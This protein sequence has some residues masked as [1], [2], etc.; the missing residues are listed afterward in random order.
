MFRLRLAAVLIG[1]G[2]VAGALFFLRATPAIAQQPEL[3]LPPMVVSATEIPTPPNEIG[4]DVT[5]IT[6]A[7]IA[8]HQWRTLP[9]VLRAVPGLVVEQAG[10]PGSAASVFIQ[11]AN[12][13]QTKVLID[14]VDVS[15]P[16]SPDGAFDFSQILVSDIARIEVLRGPQ[17][18]LYGSDAIG[19]VILIDTKEGQGPPHLTG[20]LEGGSFGSFSQDASLGGSTESFRYALNLQHDRAA[21]TPAT[22]PDLLPP[23]QPGQGN[24]SDIWNLSS[25]LGLTLSPTLAASLVA[26]YDRSLFDYTGQDDLT[27]APAAEQSQQRVEQVFSRGEISWAPV[28]VF[29]NRFGFAYTSN[30]TR[31]FDGTAFETGAA[32]VTNTIGHRYEG[33]WRGTYA[34]APQETLLFGASAERDDIAVSPISAQNGDEAGFLEWQGR[35]LEGLYGAASL[36]YDHNDRFGGI[37]TW[38]V[39]PSYTIA[40]TGTQLKLSAGTGFKAPTLN[41]LFVSYPAFDFSA[42]PDLRPEQSLGVDAGFV[43]PLMNNRV[44]FGASYFHNDIRDLIDYNDTFTSL[45]NVGRATTQGIETFV[46][47][48]ATK[49]LG[50]SASYTY[51]LAMDDE[52]SQQLLR[53]PK[54]KASVSATWRPLR[55]LT[56]VASGTYVGA[57][58]DVTYVGL[59]GATAKPYT[60]VDLDANYRLTDRV[61]LFGRI[62]NLLDEHYQDIVG[63]LRPGLAVYGGVKIS[64]DVVAPR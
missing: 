59:P 39:A 60:L 5:V 47:F 27:F 11:G 6:G 26:R 50:L 19:G 40:A 55:R 1:P 31:Q 21:D 54:H 15:N 37:A 24:L 61:T 2:A 63:F 45:V 34:V 8:R 44:R 36:R 4:S 3:P 28:S 51:T 13:N 46:Y 41:Q 42:N 23:G 35:M 9:D 58:P 25:R 14:G 7:E 62:D 32:P 48:A 52:T 49:H 16:S 33:D 38:H 22:P 56:L 18:G 12:A 64:L 53:R 43:Q 10:G 57:R 20:T 17:S 29:Q 30:A